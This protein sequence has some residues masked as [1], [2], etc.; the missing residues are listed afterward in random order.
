MINP[1]KTNAH[2]LKNIDTVNQDGQLL[3]LKGSLRVI[4]S[5]TIKLLSIKIVFVYANSAYLDE[6]PHTAAFH[7]DLN[8]L[9]NVTL[10]GFPVYTKLTG[11]YSKTFTVRGFKIC[12]STSRFMQAT[13]EDYK[14]I[15]IYLLFQIKPLMNI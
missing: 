11:F 12:P 8:C 3:I 5:K 1:W 9:Q 4:I 14:L 2:F 6:I 15:Y 10:Q 13:K 7:L